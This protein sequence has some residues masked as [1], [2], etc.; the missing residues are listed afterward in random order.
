MDEARTMDTADRFVNCKC[1]KYLL[2][3]NQTERAIEIAGLFTRASSH[4]YW[5]GIESYSDDVII[6][7]G[8]GSITNTR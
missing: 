4:V 7:G 1:V 2:R 6:T 8:A 3:I 5:Y